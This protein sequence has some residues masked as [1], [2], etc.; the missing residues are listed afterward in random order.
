MIVTDAE[1][2][3]A[4]IVILDI[5]GWGI[6]SQYL[7]DCGISELAVVVCLAELKLRI[8]QELESLIDEAERETGTLTLTSQALLF[9]NGLP[10]N[11]SL[12]SKPSDFANLPGSSKTPLSTVAELTDLENQRKQQLLARRAALQS[13]VKKAPVV[14]DGVS[15][16]K[17]PSDSPPSPSPHAREA[18]DFLSNFIPPSAGEDVLM[19]DGDHD[20]SGEVEQALKVDEDQLE[21]HL[22]TLVRQNS[23]PLPSTL[24]CPSDLASFPQGP[25]IN[26]S[27]NPK[28]LGKRPVAADF[29]LATEHSPSTSTFPSGSLMPNSWSEPVA[30][31][32][33]NS[34]SRRHF[35]PRVQE[36]VVIELTDDESDGEEHG[37]SENP[38]L[39][40]VPSLSTSLAGSTTTAPTG[41]SREGSAGPN[42]IEDE[43]HRLR[44]S[45]KQAEIE[46]MKERIRLMEEKKKRPTL[47]STNTGDVTLTTGGTPELLSDSP[48]QTGTYATTEPTNEHVQA[49]HQDVAM[50]ETRSNWVPSGTFL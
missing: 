20:S 6:P 5:L 21:S 7:L 22:S 49:G 31:S 33:T 37:A 11:H 13:T 26:T 41:A 50:V 12:P 17:S 47:L 2:F 38:K 40:P 27:T 42:A 1:L 15:A 35:G 25:T 23:P 8:P 14:P 32:F 48:Q 16:H 10:T 29:V 30:S 44:L 18:D 9:P 28:R 45:K 3:E 19:Q 43:N 34:R 39:I 36:R 24:L 46:K 4:K